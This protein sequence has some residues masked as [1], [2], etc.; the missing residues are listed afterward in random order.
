MGIDAQRENGGPAD[1]AA[2]SGKPGRNVFVVVPVVIDLVS[3]RA[4]VEGEIKAD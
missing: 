1:P 4:T 3:G 2:R